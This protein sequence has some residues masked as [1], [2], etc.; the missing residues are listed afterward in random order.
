[1]RQFYRG[2]RVCIDDLKRQ[3]VVDATPVVLGSRAFDLLLA[4]AGRHGQVVSKNELLDVVWPGSVV[5]ESNLAVHVHALRRALG[6]EA[7]LTIPGRGYQ[8][9][10]TP[11]GGSAPPPLATAPRTVPGLPA[12]PRA[13][14]LGRD[15]ELD[16]IFRRL[17]SN[18]RVVTI[19][20]T[21]GVGK[22]TLAAAVA[23]RLH[24]EACS[25][26]WAD[27]STLQDPAL[28]PAA[29]ATACK[30]ALYEG[31]DPLTSLSM[32]LRDYQ[33]LLA[34]DGA[35]HLVGAVATLAS[36]LL[37]ACPGL[38][39]LVTSQLAL[40]IPQEHQ[41]RLGGLEIAPAGSSAESARQQAAIALFERR[42]RE[43]QRRFHLTDDN[44][45][46]AIDICGRMDGL[47]FA[48]ELAASALL[49]FS[50]SELSQRIATHRPFG[51]SQL[52]NLP[53][54]QQTL[55]AALAWSYGLLAPTEQ[56]VFERLGVFPS[57]FTLAM[58]EAV[59][60]GNDLDADDFIDA[61]SVLVSRSLVTLLPAQGAGPDRYR[62]L[63]T[64]RSFARQKLAQSGDELAAQRR[65]FEAVSD[66]VRVF[67][68]LFNT[69]PLG[70]WHAIYSCELDNLRSALKWGS[71]HD[72]RAALRLLLTGDT[73]F[74]ATGQ[75]AEMLACCLS[76]ERFVDLESTEE[77]EFAGRFCLVAASGLNSISR[78]RVHHYRRLSLAIFR[79]H[80]HW[81]R[82]HWALSMLGV[83]FDLP[84]QERDALLQEAASIEQPDWRREICIGYMAQATGHF[85]AGQRQ[86]AHRL[87]AKALEMARQEFPVFVFDFLRRLA[88]LEGDSGHLA[89]ALI[90]AAEAEQM[91]RHTDGSFRAMGLA[92]LFTVH[93]RMG[94]VVE[95]R[96]TAAFLEPALRADGWM[97]HAGEVVATLPVF[98]L[99]EGRL[100]D[101]AHLIG[102]RNHLLEASGHGNAPEVQSLIHDARLAQ[103]EAAPP[104]SSIAQIIAS[105][106]G[107]HPQQAFDV[108]LRGDNDPQRLLLQRSGAAPVQGL[109]S[110]LEQL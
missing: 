31:S 73:L 27:L 96:S 110:L 47:P 108:A 86:E 85:V 5:E 74:I 93:V 4:L 79:R 84:A 102:H 59:C 1:M 15:A 33:G 64:S 58:A 29:V 17:Q 92:A 95:A 80:G 75:R 49:T 9:S 87:M 8:F 13:E 10:L 99:L 104:G 43:V 25:I 67:G 54:R 44:V 21:G 69:M 2:G 70:E 65:H 62:L 55:T 41:V 77:S 23:H 83:Q 72:G 78:E 24:D 46:M 39:L 6:K 42:G 26:G 38:C 71:Q 36:A 60:S 66:A 90:H 51:R 48:I 106:H 56:R 7:I 88:E 97:I 30:V 81:R 103:L 14:L 53:A 82:L 28:L 98:C 3:L 32:A 101:A 50:L 89:D 52:R 91:T 19:V 16:D 12:D 61:L 22:S 45:A 109:G 11:D 20:G 57:S 34:L 94:A 18:G 68:P 37:V 100:N 63:E 76:L 40:Q 107:L 105:G 35:E